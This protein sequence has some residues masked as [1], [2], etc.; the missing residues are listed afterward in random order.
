MWCYT[1]RVKEI[2][3]KTT[4][5]EVHQHLSTSCCESLGVRAILPRYSTCGT[6]N[7]QKRP[8]NTKGHQ[9]IKHHSALCRQS[10]RHNSWKITPENLHSSNINFAMQLLARKQYTPDISSHVAST[11][12]SRY[13]RH[14]TSNKHN[15]VKTSV[16]HA[17]RLGLVVS[18]NIVLQQQ[19]MV[20]CD[21]S[22]DVLIKTLWLAPFIVSWF[23]ILDTPRALFIARFLSVGTSDSFHLK[24]W[25]S[26]HISIIASTHGG[27]SRCV[28]SACFGTFF[29]GGTSLG[30]Q[31]RPSGDADSFKGISV[32][33]KWLWIGSNASIR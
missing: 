1:Q 31:N 17:H 6:K 25:T 22:H 27:S 28:S 11:L 32:A 19:N 16:R 7:N 2:H 29:L 30:W 10:S 3:L 33:K 14:H 5:R 26:H 4:K 21:L 18:K 12:D 24:V 20:A 9:K 23:R 8:L 13:I 15:P